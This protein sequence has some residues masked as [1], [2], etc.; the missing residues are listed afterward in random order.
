MTYADI[1]EIHSQEKSRKNVG[2]LQ[3]IDEKFYSNFASTYNSSGAYKEYL[4][5]LGEGIYTERVKIILIHALR[6]N[7]GNIKEPVNMTK[8][9]KEIYNKILDILKIYE[10]KFL[11]EKEKINEADNKQDDEKVSEV[12]IKFL[13]S[14]PG[15]VGDDLRRFGPFSYEDIVMITGPLAKILINSGFAEFV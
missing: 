8:E 12:K 5:I 3:K 9:E 13:N 15:I 11:F 2:V 6:A 10:N 1:E 4:R 7:T 14:C